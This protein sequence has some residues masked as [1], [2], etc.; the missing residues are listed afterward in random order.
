MRQTQMRLSL[1]DCSTIEA[2]RS[3][4]VQRRL[5]GHAEAI[6]PTVSVLKHAL[7][8]MFERYANTGDK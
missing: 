8:F 7:H 2:I 1:E 6:D 5:K 4:V 3:K